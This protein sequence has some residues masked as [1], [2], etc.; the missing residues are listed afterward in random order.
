MQEEVRDVRL[1]QQG[2]E[3]KKRGTSAMVAHYLKP[4]KPLVQ[5]A[6]DE[7]SKGGQYTTDT[8]SDGADP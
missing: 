3:L 2:M 1:Q 4:D 8:N 7:K 6:N 5:I